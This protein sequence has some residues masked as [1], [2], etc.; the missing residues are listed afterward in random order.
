MTDDPRHA[1]S[2]ETDLPTDS[3]TGV[4]SPVVTEDE[5]LVV[6][7]VAPRSRTGLVPALAWVFRR[8]LC[9]GGLA[10]ALVALCC[11]LTPS[12]LPRGW[13]AQGVV[14]GITTTIGYGLGSML[15]S[16]IRKVVPREVSPG[17]R[18]LAWTILLVA[19]VSLVPLFLF[20]AAQ[21]QEKVREVMGMELLDSFHWLGM[22]ALAVIVAALLLAVS[23]VVRGGTRALIRLVDRWAPRPVAR[24]MGVAVAALVVIG[25]VQGV[26]L[27]AMVDALDAAYSVSD[28]GTSNGVAQ[29]T[30]SLRSGGPESLVPWDTLGVKGRDFAGDGWAES[31]E[32]LEAFIDGPVAEP[33][34]VYVGLD[35]ADSLAARVDLAVRELERT[36]AFDREVLV[37]VTTTG[38][39]WVDANVSNSIEY[40]YAG[41]T[42]I[43]ALQYSYL[44]SW[45][46]FLV[47]RSKA[48]GAADAMLAGVTERWAEEPEDTR[49]ELFAF[50]ESLGSYGTEHSFDDLDDMATT[51]DGVLLEGPTFANPIRNDL[52]DHRDDG[53]PEW[54]PVYR[55]GAVTRF[56][57]HPGDF[58][59]VPG[60]WSRPRVAYLQNATDPIS[61]FS[62]DLLWSR[63]DWLR[64]PRAPDV[65]RDMAWLPVVTFWQV[66][67]DLA[68]AGSVPDGHGHSYGAAAVD[69]WAAVAA[70]EG[71][72]AAD[73]DRLKSAVARDIDQIDEL[74][75]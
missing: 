49:A 22:L 29:P 39:G 46:S 69:G 2:T 14:S 64:A 55:S 72:T 43:V 62:F 20:L 50:G 57:D 65:S 47:D 32:D 44:P 13:V 56:E 10:G 36:G 68:L 59:A 26:L 74:K 53:S 33:I 40:M 67:A 28:G 4:P 34:R 52:T 21:W 5:N 15:S 73:S 71:W 6:E 70:P 1:L 37:V 75:S 27:D 61:F 23:R 38:T 9:F 42:A 24:V 25:V 30:S 8:R 35:S 60:T 31:T 51:L 12:L 11:S 17:A 54:L 66:A 16:W 45:V 3:A 48:A 7:R 41:D 18:R 19:T 63:P 58:A